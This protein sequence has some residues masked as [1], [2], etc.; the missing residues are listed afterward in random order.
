MWCEV[1]CGVEWCVC[2]CVCG[3]MCGVVCSVVWSSMVWSGVVWSGVVWCGVVCHVVCC[4]VSRQSAV[5]VFKMVRS[6]HHL[7][8]FHHRTQQFVP[9]RVLN[10]T[11]Q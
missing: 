7:A 11:G 2:V 4:N 3:M 6:V 5:S 8:S 9:D 10:V 1:V